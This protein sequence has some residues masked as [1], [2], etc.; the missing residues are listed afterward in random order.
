MT[1]A[2]SA[3]TTTPSRIS[4]LSAGA[5]RRRPSEPRDVPSAYAVHANGWM[6]I[7]DHPGRG[8]A[9]YVR[10]ER[11]PRK[12]KTTAAAATEY[13]RRTIAWR[14]HFA[15]FKR[16]RREAIDHPRYAFLEAAE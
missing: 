1:Q 11:F 14:A 2:D 3:H 10:F 16:R 12:V 4:F 9:T 7:I 15:G 8:E 5:V 13:A 6:P